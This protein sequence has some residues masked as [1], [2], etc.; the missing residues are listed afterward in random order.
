MDEL[1]LDHGKKTMGQVFG[2]EDDRFQYLVRQIDLYQEHTNKQSEVIKKLWE[3][4]EF[5]DQEK[6]L[7][8]YIFGKMSIPKVIPVPIPS[9]IIDAVKHLFKGTPCEDKDVN[10]IFEE[11][12]EA[13][14]KKE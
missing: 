10:K 12:Q 8:T 4:K 5:T 1:K 2:L 13:L 6:I 14:R 11:M 9:E 7:G 3:N